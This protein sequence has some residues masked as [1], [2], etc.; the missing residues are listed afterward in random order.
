MKKRD[1]TRVVGFVRCSTDEQVIGPEAQRRALQA[2]CNSHGLVLAATHEDLGVSGGAPLDKRAGL[3]AALAA[4]DA[5]NAGVLLGAKRDRL[6]RDVVLSAMIERLVERAGA[7]VLS[8][9]G[10]GNGDGP[11][12]AVMRHIVA[13]FSEYERALIRSRTRAALAVKKARGERVGKIP[14]G[15]KLGSDDKL[16][17][18]PVEQRALARIAELRAGEK[19]I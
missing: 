15:F 9:D 19:T 13:A 6:A 7:R 16:V 4:L 8:C 11:E 17:P 18:D 10:T 3:V 14:L 1:A 5:E 12:Q 2:Y